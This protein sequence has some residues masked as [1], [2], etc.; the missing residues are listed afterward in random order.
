MTNRSLKG[1]LA[2]AGEASRES[3][4]KPGQ[5]FLHLLALAGLAIAQPVYDLFA[6]HVD[7]FVAHDSQPLDLVLLTVLFSLAVPLVLAV[8]VVA[9]G[10]LHRRAGRISLYALLGLLAGL[11]ALPVLKRV[12]FLDDFALLAVA[13]L[14]GAA[15]LG[16]YA[17]FSRVRE[18]VSLLSIGALLFPLHFLLLSG[19]RP[20]VF[21][22]DSQADVAATPRVRGAPVIFLIFEEAPVISLMDENHQIDAVRY[23]SFAALARQAYWFRNYTVHSVSTKLSVPAILTGRHVEEAS[24]FV[25]EN[26]PESLFTLLGPGY[27]VVARGFSKNIC[28]AEFQVARQRDSLARRVVFMVRDVSVVYLHIVLPQGLT[29]HLP[30]VT[31]D[32]RD[33]VFAP[34]GSDSD[35]P[36]E[37]GSGAPDQPWNWRASWKETR[38]GEDLDSFVDGLE[39]V[40]ES[41]L[42][43]LHAKLVHIPWILLP[44][45][46][47][48]DGGLQGLMRL[49]RGS[50]PAVEGFGGKL[51]STDE[52]LVA[53]GY[54][55]H[56]L[57]VGAADRKLGRLLERLRA[58]GVFDESL[59][60]V[61]ADHGFAF[62]PGGR[63][64]GHKDTMLGDA[65]AVPLIIK[66]PHQETAV[67]SDDNV[68][69]IDV[70]PTIADALGI[71]IPWPVD[72]RSALDPSSPPREHKTLLHLPED[73]V[74]SLNTGVAVG[75]R[76]M[77]ASGAM[78]FR[79]LEWK[80]ELFGSGTTRP[81]GYFAFGPY[82][83]LVGRGLAEVPRDDAL[84]GGLRVSLSWHQRS[85]DLATAEVLPALLSGQ[86]AGGVA[87]GDPVHL[88]VA[89]N[90]VVRAVTRTELD[91]PGKA[92]R[93]HALLPEEAFRSGANEVEVLRILRDES[94]QVVLAALR[95]EAG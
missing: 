29:A 87:S 4:P 6:R 5:V 78:V 89:M 40:G 11:T 21:P 22:S 90:G 94:G 64:R 12:R 37:T 95:P 71:E 57:E 13:G 92:G 45:G 3:E 24:P 85:V 43:F 52:W 80:L 7:F 27:R 20:L 47:R 48:Y 72:G 33:F 61:T 53:Q 15:F 35:A 31:D 16:A 67:I 82:G 26:F 79:R 62:E 93:F 69:A 75:R 19:A 42:H 51:W 54:Q 91:P 81:D 63:N 49:R 77:D 44:S 59:I 17:R 41:T 66:L 36:A 39:G 14:L 46:K 88:A 30:R 2:G 65:L 50:S 38:K 23:P 70:L 68:E 10:R 1:L 83:D 9:S 58:L 8:L 32:W 25:A 84:G 55:R 73:R 56:L 60:V 86:L 76:L 34:G 28:P 18:L 74:A